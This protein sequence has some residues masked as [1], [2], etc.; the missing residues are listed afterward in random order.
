MGMRLAGKVCVVTGAGRGLGRAFARKLAD[1]GASVVVAEIDAVSGAAVAAE[2]TGADGQAVFV[3]TDVADEAN[4]LA[5]AARAVEAFGRLDVLVNNAAIYDG[6]RRASFDR[7]TT[8]EWDRVM[9][10]NVRGTWN[11]C[12]AVVPFMQRDGG[13][14]I[15]NLSSGTVYAGTPF[16]LHYVTSK[17][18]IIAMTRALANELG[19]FGITVNA[20]VPGLTDSGARKVWDGVSPSDLPPM[21]RPLGRDATPEDLVGTMVYLA[22]SD[23]DFMT[24]QTIHVNGGSVFG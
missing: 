2:I 8:E 15:I 12:R 6:I 4:T 13:G 1:E 23:S 17:G 5:M 21:S 19:R 10:V 14:K 20:L 3:E 18:A 11:C 22:S 7:L 24:G 16:L 9:A